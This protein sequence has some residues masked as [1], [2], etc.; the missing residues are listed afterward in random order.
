MKRSAVSQLGPKV[1]THL[2]LLCVL[3][4][5]VT[6]TAWAEPAL[7]LLVTAPPEL[8]LETPEGPCSQLK[9]P[10]T[11]AATQADDAL[12]SVRDAYV[13]LDF[14]EALA[15]LTSLE[16]QRLEALR[17]ETELGALCRMLS[18]RVEL[19]QAA[20]RPLEHTLKRHA[21]L[22][23]R[24]PADPATVP[25]GVRTQLADAAK[26]HAAQAP[27]PI[28]L[29]TEPKGT[30]LRIDGREVGRAPQT[31]ALRPGRHWVT[32]DHPGHHTQSV[33]LKITP[34]S[35]DERTL[36]LGPPSLEALSAQH[37][38]G[39]AKQRAALITARTYLMANFGFDTLLR[40]TPE[41]D[42][43][44]FAR[45]DL[46]T[47]TEHQRQGACT[48]QTATPTP[49]VTAAPVAPPK[50]SRRRR[51]WLWTSVGILAAGALATTLYLTLRRP[52]D[53]V[54]ISL[55]QD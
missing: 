1:S 26:T 5:F 30:V 35:P 3:V 12:Q 43:C 40:V 6:R 46:R 44:S 24:F 18:L 2:G 28:T 10:A 50:R 17:D 42:D 19:E 39:N 38:Q 52:T 36:K 54:R 13:R 15:R 7:C 8:E 45:I 55:T 4:P 33:P 53:R 14:D 41:G 23:E 51:P 29:R 48:L 47:G 20:E 49:S 31:L 25:P 9:R 27:V 16:Q 22:C 11:T 34:D 21:T 37:Q 32:L